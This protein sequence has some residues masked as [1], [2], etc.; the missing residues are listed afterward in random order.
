[1]S[2]KAR[3]IGENCLMSLDDFNAAYSAYFGIMSI[4]VFGSYKRYSNEQLWY[5]YG[6]RKMC[7]FNVYESSELLGYSNTFVV[8]YSVRNACKILCPYDVSYSIDFAQKWHSFRSY[9]RLFRK[10]LT[11]VERQ[12]RWREKHA[13][14]KKRK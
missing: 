13:N 14:K 4:D 10:P 5:I 8:G 6:L 3:K 9:C 2:S 7:G 11:N 1:M 12:K